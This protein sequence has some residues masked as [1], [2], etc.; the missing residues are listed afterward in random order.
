VFW[1]AQLTLL[2]RNAS[3]QFRKWDRHCVA[4][5]ECCASY[6]LRLL[7]PSWYVGNRIANEEPPRR[8]CPAIWTCFGTAYI[9]KRQKF[10]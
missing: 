10:T 8:D 9:R 5:D 7:L 4:R 6:F 3:S 2:S 1:R